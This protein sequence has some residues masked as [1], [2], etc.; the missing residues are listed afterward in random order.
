MFHAYLTFWA[1]LTV[2]LTKPYI[3]GVTGS[4]GKTTTTE[5]LASVLT[6]ERIAKIIGKTEYS[7]DNLNNDLGLPAALLLFEDW[8]RVPFNFW[9]KLRMMVQL[10][11]HVASIL[12]RYPKF[13]VL[14]YGA[15]SDGHIP[16]LVSVVRPDIAI[17]TT[18]GPAHLSRF[19]NTLGVAEEKRILL[20]AVPEFGLV[21]I[22]EDHEYVSF[23]Q[24]GVKAN[25]VTLPGRGLEL[26]KLITLTF[27][28]QTV[29]KY[30][31]QK[32]VLLLV[33]Q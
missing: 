7:K 28:M 12:I 11:F 5:M 31:L 21:L 22:G 32:E 27:T 17:L 18:I 19:N 2:S 9:G 30:F 10:P 29:N 20:Q 8:N 6:N 1:K 24:Q 4:V 15:G 16:Y 14:E 25:I 33:T 13:L 26:S 3:I 23:L